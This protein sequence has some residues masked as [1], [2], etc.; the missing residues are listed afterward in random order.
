MRTGLIVEA[1]GGH[2]W[3]AS[4]NPVPPFINPKDTKKWKLIGVLCSKIEFHRMSVS[5]QTMIAR[6]LVQE[7]INGELLRGWDHAAA[8]MV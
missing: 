1:G 5:E 7:K 8:R 3:L 6:T 2:K 4:R